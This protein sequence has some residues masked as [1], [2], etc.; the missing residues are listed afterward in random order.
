MI[1]WQPDVFLVSGMPGNGKSWF[2]INYSNSISNTI[3][4][5]IDV[6]FSYMRDSFPI[7]DGI[8]DTFD[9]YRYVNSV[10]FDKIE[11]LRLF[12]EK[13]LEFM[14]DKKKC[15]VVIIEGYV[16]EIL[17]EEIKQTL[18]QLYNFENF[19][20][21]VSRLDENGYGILI[22]S[23]HVGY[24]NQKN[25]DNIIRNIHLILIEQKNIIRNTTYQQYP[26]TSEINSKSEEKYEK[27]IKN[28]NLVGKTFIDFGCNSGWFCFRAK[29]RGAL[30]TIGIDRGENWIKLANDINNTIYNYGNMEWHY[31][32]VFDFN[33][34]TTYDI[35][36][37]A[38]TFHYFG[39]KQKQFIE[40][41]HKMSNENSEVFLEV[42]VSPKKD[43][44]VDWASRNSDS[45]PMAYPSMNGFLNMLVD[46][47]NIESTIES[48]FQP[49]SLYTRYFFKLRKI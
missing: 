19:Y 39:E 6:L 5:H 24:A 13:F 37:C 35:I 12:E 48:A 9:I 11:F 4:Y 43:I 33:V 20:N 23:Q 1:W 47:F 40:I 15:N 34:E 7:E 46:L 25:Y 41:V 10:H 2:S 45:S 49:G 16:C 21:V 3:I 29:E 32:D 28:C 36:F 42:E 31:C 14:V 27:S 17:N 26:W 30:K 22:N 18:R 44:D 38:S 8:K